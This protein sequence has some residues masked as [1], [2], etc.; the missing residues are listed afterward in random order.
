MNDVT[1]TEIIQTVRYIPSQSDG[2]SIRDLVITIW[3]RKIILLVT[4]A[5]LT[6]LTVVVLQ[7]VT[8]LYTANAELLIETRG[9]N[10]ANPDSAV[11]SLAVDNATIIS[12]IQIIRSR[13]LAQRLITQLGLD[14]NSEFN[15]S[16]RE[17]STED[18]NPR[19]L[20]QRLI[21]KLGLD[22]TTEFNPAF[23]AKVTQDDQRNLL[24]LGSLSADEYQQQ[25]ERSRLMASFLDQLKV[26]QISSSRVIAI[27]F[28]ATN[29]MTATRVVNTLMELY[30]EQQRNSKF[31]D[32]R[33]ATEWLNQNISS[34]RKAVEQSEK[35]VELFRQNS[36]L[37]EGKEGTLLTVEQISQLN[38]QL[39]IAEANQTE[40]N[41]RL[42]QIKKLIRSHGD[43]ESASEVLDSGLIQQI[44]IQETELQRQIA[45][46]STEFGRRHPKMIN[47]VASLDGLQNK[48]TAEVRKVVMGLENEVAIASSRVWSL[49]TSLNRL[50]GQAADANQSIVRLNAL[51]REAEANRVLL[52]TFLSRVKETT[53]QLDMDIQQPDASV[54]SYANLPIEPSFPKTVPILLLA[55]VASS[56]IGFMLVF[57]VEYFDVGSRKRLSRF[58]DQSAE[59][60]QG[61]VVFDP[62]D[63]KE[64]EAK[65]K[66]AL[67]NFLSR[68]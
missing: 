30:I 53:S 63:R 42:R 45:E 10:I 27:E 33:R 36:G 37:I 32:T 23:R 54:V 18:D 67:N 26:Y 7:H 68:V 8:P 51:E 59:V 40:A 13:N 25:L 50:K 41:V 56:L 55:L 43:I 61:V 34:L 21:A 1:N 6:Y 47:L 9:R 38:S 66:N 17:K 29:P 52:N 44:R 48:L 31:E 57:I 28:S 5:A 46:I 22:R 16:L 14:R 3:R 19:S 2:F 58:K 24:L 39:T 60:Q 4:I 64:D 65:Q 20:T 49:R 12:E 11:A 35:E 62:L 15:H